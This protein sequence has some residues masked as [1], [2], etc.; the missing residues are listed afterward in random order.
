MTLIFPPVPRIHFL[1]LY[2]ILHAINSYKTIIIDW[3]LTL[4]KVMCWM[5]DTLSHFMLNY[6]IIPLT[7]KLRPKEVWMLA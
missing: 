1:Y 7:E 4:Y 6:K 3:V 2:E 5:L